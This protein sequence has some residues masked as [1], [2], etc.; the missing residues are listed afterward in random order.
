MRI[1]E[2]AFYELDAPVARVCSAEVPTPYAKHM[3][4]AAMPQVEAIVAAARGV[5]ARD[6]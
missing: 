1:M 3:E 5:L 2:Q 4:D 6:G